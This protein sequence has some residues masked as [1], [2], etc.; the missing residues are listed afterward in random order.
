MFLPTRCVSSPT[1]VR[2]QD[3]FEELRTIVSEIEEADLSE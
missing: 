1:P 3:V 2:I